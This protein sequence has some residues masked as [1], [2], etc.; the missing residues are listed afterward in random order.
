MER[1]LSKLVSAIRDRAQQV[2]AA[3]RRLVI[4]HVGC[5]QRAAALLNALE[6][7]CGFA[8]SVICRSGG[9]ST[10]YANRGGVIVSF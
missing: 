9:L 6:A 3:G 10:T 4:T 1:A 8:G 2:G 7:T 5:P